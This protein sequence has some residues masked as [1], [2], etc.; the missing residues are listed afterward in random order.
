[1]NTYK[2][3]LDKTATNG[4]DIEIEVIMDYSATEQ[5]AEVMLGEATRKILA[6]INTGQLDFDKMP[7][8]V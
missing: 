4:I 1:M 2:V 3:R 5:G 7:V 6:A 8:R